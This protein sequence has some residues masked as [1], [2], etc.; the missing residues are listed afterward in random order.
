[1]TQASAKQ[2]FQTYG[3]LLIRS[4]AG[5]YTILHPDG[6]TEA[7]GMY[8]DANGACFTIIKE[9]RDVSAFM[10]AFKLDSFEEIKT[11]SWAAF[12]FA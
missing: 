1:M 9:Y 7:T 2:Y 3:S 12:F 8:K 4:E 5:I 11:L 10:K 6:T